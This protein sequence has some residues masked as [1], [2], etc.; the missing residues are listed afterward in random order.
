M[1][2]RM[3]KVAAGRSFIRSCFDPVLDEFNRLRM[4]S[5]G[6]IAALQGRYAEETGT[7]ALKVKH[8]NQL[9]Y[10]VEVAQVAGE[11]LLKPPHSATFVHRQ[12]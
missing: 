3:G 6:V 8:N 1:R 2:R 4:D 10:Y 5:Q 11:A 12:T 7:R 9:G